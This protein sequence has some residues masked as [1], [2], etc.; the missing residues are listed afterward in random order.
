MVCTF[1]LKINDMRYS[2]EAKHRWLC[3]WK[4]SGESI[5]Q[6]CKDKPF[7]TGTFYKW[8][9]QWEGEENTPSGSG[10]I[11]LPIS[12][13]MPLYMTIQYPGGVKIDIHQ[14]MSI[15]HIRKLAGC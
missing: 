12:G 4:D 14:P 10:F 11:P 6:F 13:T 9:S 15:E 8:V 5:L 2:E 1:V 7:N 3:E